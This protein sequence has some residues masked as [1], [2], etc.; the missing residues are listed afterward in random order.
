[1]DNEGILIVD[2][3]ALSKRH[4]GMVNQM[5]L[6]FHSVGA[7]VIFVECVK[8]FPTVSNINRLRSLGFNFDDIVHLHEDDYQKRDFRSLEFIEKTL[9]NNSDDVVVI[10]GSGITFQRLLKKGVAVV[11]HG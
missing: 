4:L 1:M 10:T 9:N 2:A 11:L 8:E 7:F 3:N 6:A 5:A